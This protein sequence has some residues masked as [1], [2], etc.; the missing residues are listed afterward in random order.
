MWIVKNY[1]DPA[2]RFGYEGYSAHSQYNLLP[3]AMLAIAWE[4]AE[5]TDALLEIPAPA[6]VGGFVFQLP[7]LHKVFANAGGMYVELET[8]GDSHYNATG[9]IRVHKTGMN[10]QL[11]P[12]DSITAGKAYE[13]PSGAATTAAIGAAWKDSSGK[14]HR[15]AEFQ[16]GA[17]KSAT[18][19][20]VSESQDRVAFTVTYTGAFSGPTSVVESYAVTPGGVALTTTLTGYAGPAEYVWPMLADNGAAKTDIGVDFGT[21]HTTLGDLSQTFTPVDATSVSVPATLYAF[22]NGWARLGIAD[23][24]GG[25]PMTLR[26]AP[27]VPLSLPD[28]VEALRVAGGLTAPGGTEVS[29]LD[30]DRNGTVDA[31]DA[32]TIASGTR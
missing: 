31:M 10:P 17:I 23:Y 13:A 11:G 27:Q 3:M 21:V 25:G 29:Q 16:N 22:H 26:I 20:D 9:L 12:S 1:F 2:T 14:W 18:L 7:Q 8:N 5:S 24:A 28:A 15:L 4:H 32:L 30:V 6:D 19:S